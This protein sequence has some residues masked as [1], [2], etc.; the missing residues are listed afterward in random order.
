MWASIANAQRR[1][2]GGLEATRNRKIAVQAV[3]GELD[4]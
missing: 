2:V 4:S 3:L 1:F